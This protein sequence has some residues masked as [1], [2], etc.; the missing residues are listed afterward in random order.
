MLSIHLFNT[1]KLRKIL[2]YVSRLLN[3]FFWDFLKIICGYKFEDQLPLT[4]P[5]HNI[6][7]HPPHEEIKYKD[8]IPRRDQRI[9]GVP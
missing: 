1:T 5:L 2:H 8:E 3:F 7:G 6:G 9:L 4:P